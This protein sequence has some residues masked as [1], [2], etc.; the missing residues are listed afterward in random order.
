M[1]KSRF[2]KLLESRSRERLYSWTSYEVKDRTFGFAHRDRDRARN[3]YVQVFPAGKLPSQSELEW[4]AMEDEIDAADFILK[5]KGDPGI[6]DFV[7]YSR[8]TLL[9]ATEFL[10]R[11]MIHAHTANVIGTGVPRIGPADDGSVDL[12]WEKSDRTLLVNFPAR[13][14]FANYYGKKPKSEISGKFD[15][16]ESR[17]ELVFWLAD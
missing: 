3:E 13:Q 15:P 7:P 5:I 14:G 8:D 1:P 12:F 11:L 4:R 16:S 17:P 2:E 10:C 9:R 6:E